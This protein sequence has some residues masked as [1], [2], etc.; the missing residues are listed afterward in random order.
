MRKQLLLLKSLLVAAL[1]GMGSNAWAD[2]VYTSVYSRAAV[3][4]WTSDDKTDWSASSAVEVNATYGLGADANQTVTYVTKTF[5]TKENSKIKYEVDW[6]FG[7]ATGRT[8]N[9]NWI[10]F[11]NF[12]R[13]AIN[14][15]YDMQV[16]TDAGSNWNATVLAHYSNNVFTKHIEVIFDTQKKTVEK[17]T[18]DGTDRTSLVSGTFSTATFNTVST[19]FIRGGSVGWN[20]KNYITTISV[21]EAEQAAAADAT[22]TINYKYGGETIYSDAGSSKE[23]V[24]IY[25]ENPITIS[26]QRYFAAENEITSKTLV[27]G[28]NVLDVN[29]RLPNVYNY[30]VVARDGS[31]NKLGDNI[32]SGSY[33]EGDDAI[34]VAYSQH[35]LSG[36]TLY[37]IEKNATG[38]WFRKT[39]TPDEDNYELT[40]TYNGST[41]PN[42]VFFTEA[43]DVTNA[44]VGNYTN[45][46]SNGQVG[47][48]GSATTYLDVT[49]LAPGKY[50][51]YAKGLNGN[52]AAK[53]A[54]FKLG[55]N[56]FEFSI[57]QG[58]DQ[59]GNSEEFLIAENST[60]SFGSEGHASNGG[61][62]WFYVVKTGDVVNFT[63]G[64]DAGNSYK[65]YVTKGNTDFATLGVTAYIAKAADTTNGEVTLSTIATAP[66]NTPVL[67]KGTKGGYAAISTTT[68]SYDAPETNY[69][70]AAD[71][72]TAIGSNDVKYVL[73]YDNGWEF[74]HY[75]GTLSAGKVYLDLS[76]MGAR[77]TKFS[78][79]FDDKTTGISDTTRL[80]DKG[81]MTNGVFNLKGQRVKKATKGLY[82]KNGK[83]VVIK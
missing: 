50:K 14:S 23:G 41:I 71:G 2:D 72:E 77:A 54:N 83:K 46:A 75:N 25:A 59:N 51:I 29:L 44:S 66:A 35:R 80:K 68:T 42:V 63:L 7:C 39:F 20:I 79:V 81:Q 24:T 33:T 10:Q 34:T 3:G 48:T 19:G 49:T 62:D 1:L 58:T 31:G 26:D 76:T 52:Q 12:L 27:A 17:F 9:W 61:V 67:L 38:D 21:S 53:S 65:S 22:Y 40:L 16:S 57:T 6:S 18:F 37:T 55:E 43:E 13:I 4:N 60:L 36:T 15:S 70:K 30:S 32:A 8:N 78:F 69:L 56:V 64:A 47:Y 11:G 82:I 28:A 45:R 73:A 5:T 74:R